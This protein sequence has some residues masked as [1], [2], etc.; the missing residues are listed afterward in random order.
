[1]TLRIGGFL[2]PSF[3]VKHGNFKKAF[4]KKYEDDTFELDDSND[5]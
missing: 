4:N 1:M 5:R 3:Y 2:E